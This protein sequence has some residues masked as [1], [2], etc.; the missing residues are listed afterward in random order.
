MLTILLLLLDCIVQ[1]RVLIFANAVLVMEQWYSLP[2]SFLVE[3]PTT[4]MDNRTAFNYPSSTVSGS[5]ISSMNTIHPNQ[6]K[7][8][9]RLLREDNINC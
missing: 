2:I 8:T 1:V 7:D 4:T 9:I 6:W 5:Y 3:Y